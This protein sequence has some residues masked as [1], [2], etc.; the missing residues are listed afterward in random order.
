MDTVALHRKQSS[1]PAGGRR[2]T[3]AVETE[4]AGVGEKKKV[5]PQATRSCR[6]RRVAMGGVCPT[7]R[8]SSQATRE[9]A[10][11][12]EHPASLARKCVYRCK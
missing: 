3:G 10:K 12:R 11:S 7:T 4:I 1:L 8:K 6:L 9:T 2:E 5:M